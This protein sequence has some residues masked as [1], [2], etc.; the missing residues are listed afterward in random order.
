MSIKK[1]LRLD[2]NTEVELE[3]RM[4]SGSV[5]GRSCAVVEEPVNRFVSSYDDLWC[6][7]YK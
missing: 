2:R 4:K 7:L 5:F 1:F 6:N 3:T